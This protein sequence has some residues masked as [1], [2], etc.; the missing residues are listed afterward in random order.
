MLGRKLFILRKSPLIFLFALLVT[1]GVSIS[2]ADAQ[3]KPSTNISGTLGLNTIPSARVDKVGTIRLG[4]GT[5]EPY[6]NTF[7]GFQLS[8]PLYVQ[9]RQ[10]SE[11]SNF[12]DG[13]TRLYPGVDFK[14]NVFSETKK[15]PAVS[16]GLNSA[17]GHKRTSSEYIALSKRY[18][19]F[20]FTLGAGWGRLAGKG[21]FKNPLS[22]IS[23]HFSKERNFNN[24]NSQQIDNWF[25]GEEIGFF[26]GVE[27]ATPFKGLSLK[28]DIGGYDY[29]LEENNISNFNA[30][31]PWSLGVNYTPTIKGYSP[32][33]VSA[34]VVGGERIFARLS[35][36]GNVKNWS[37][38]TDKSNVP[39]EVYTPRRA[40]LGHNKARLDLSPHQ[41]S[42]KQIGRQARYLANQT[43]QDT[44]ALNLQLYN[45][46]LAGPEIMI[47]RRSLEQ[48]TIHKTNSAEEIWHKVTFKPPKIKFLTWSKYFNQ[49]ASEQ[50]SGEI[51][52]DNKLG[53]S[54]NDSGVLFRNALIFNIEKKLPWGF[55]TGFAPRVN[56]TSNLPIRTLGNEGREDEALFAA[57]G[58]GF[59]NAYLSWLYSLS[60]NTHLH[61]SFGYLEEMFAGY[62]GEILHRPFGK[63]YAIGA[64][65][66]QVTK[67]EARSEQAA[68]LTDNKSLTGHVNVFYELP[69]EQTTLFAKA[70]KYLA[71]DVGGT[72][73]IK[74]NFKNGT[75]LEAFVTGTN[76]SDTSIFG[77]KTN[78]YSGMRLT[79]PI[80]NIPLIPENTK[81]RLTTAPFARTTG[82]TLDKHNDLYEI[83][84][85]IAYRHLSQSW[86]HLLD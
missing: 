11:F 68:A 20:D 61:A 58:L 37:G 66:W 38:R 49:D 60:Q 30:P 14:Y 51:I 34:G 24:E 85:P 27:Y 3:S 12:S 67:R 15:R 77:G 64:E 54:E 43:Y 65:A 83:T 78:L 10:T 19:N 42:A 44:E 50:R 39:P 75:K 41:S 5:A 74:N 4:A 46:G 36:Q 72:L 6:F 53:L 28:A 33:Q 31:A 48:A 40:H 26:G 2:V 63:R 79:L 7:I 62:G 84:E 71:G 35:F 52:L 57:Q 69:D 32:A 47:P 9:L 29:G 59:E 16:L 17:I 1:A 13:A 18:D 80:G 56:L 21:H 81:I 23:S 25:T 86:N 73:G 55:R 82:Q 8:K 76:K 22:G 70:G 45:K